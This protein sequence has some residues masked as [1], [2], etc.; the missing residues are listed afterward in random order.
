[1]PLPLTAFQISWEG[2]SHTFYQLR[3]LGRAMSFNVGWSRE[4]GLFIET[5]ELY[6]DAD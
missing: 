4:R 3:D 5:D 6:T 2:G 1:M